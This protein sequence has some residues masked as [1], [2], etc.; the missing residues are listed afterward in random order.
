MRRKIAQC[1]I[2]AKETLG[3]AHGQR[4]IER[5]GEVE[6]DYRCGK[7]IHADHE[8]GVAVRCCMDDE[9]RDPHERGNQRDAMT[10]AV[11]NFFPSRLLALGS[12]E[13]SPGCQ[14]QR[15]PDRNCRT[16]APDQL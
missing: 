1:S 5:G 7:K 9:K 13:P 12:A 3:G 11:S 4:V 2:Y 14:L 8:S 15:E 16:A 10:D 6:D